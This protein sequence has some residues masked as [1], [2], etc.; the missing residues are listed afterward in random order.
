MQTILHFLKPYKWRCLFTLL[1]MI[2]D[3]AGSLFI[4]TI[5]A[6]MINIGVSGGDMQ[7]LIHNGLLMLIIA[8]ITSLGALFGSYLS[9]N[10]SAKIGQDMRNA[11]YD[12]SLTFSSYW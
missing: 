3:V 4:P 7:Y 12:K 10:L 2:L 11:L 5:T 6:N 1:V 8:L 9:A